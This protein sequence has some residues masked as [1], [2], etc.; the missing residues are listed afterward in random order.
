M[1]WALVPT[2]EVTSASRVYISASVARLFE[3]WP[4][5]VGSSPTL[6]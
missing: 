4:S 5:M 6:L 2:A 1:A 3:S